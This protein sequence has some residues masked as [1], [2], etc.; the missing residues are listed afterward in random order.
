[1][2]HC[3]GYSC[4]LTPLSELDL[5]CPGFRLPTEAE[6]EYFARAGT[7]TPFITESGTLT[8]W[9][10][11]VLDPEMDAIAWYVANSAVSYSPSFD[12]SEYWSG[13]GPCGPHP[14]AQK[15]P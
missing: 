15:V 7:T 9:N 3:R 1:E 11:D 8:N 12:C 5:D 10:P 2:D 4:D 14:V 13:A 6:W